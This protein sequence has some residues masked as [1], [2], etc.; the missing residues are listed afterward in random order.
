MR[1]AAATLAAALLAAGP[2]VAADSGWTGR[3]RGVLENYPGRPGTERIDVEFEAGPMPQ[4]EGDCTTW[5]THYRHDGQLRQTKDYRL[6]RLAGDGEF[7]VDEGD[8][9]KLPTRLLGGVMYSVF[10]VGDVL[11][12]VI[13]RRRGDTIEQEIVTATDR[14]AGAGVETLHPRSV[15]RMTLRRAPR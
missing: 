10:K 11:L 7:V 14:P 12:T 2:A 4:R 6:C 5:R 3:W 1:A 9:I 15:Q 8:G 13:T